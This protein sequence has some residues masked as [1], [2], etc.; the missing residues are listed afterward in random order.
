MKK[1]IV[2]FSV[3]IIII[4]IAICSFPKTGSVCLEEK[5]FEVEV[6]SNDK[7][8]ALGLMFRESLDQNKGMLF[9][10]K[11]EDNYSFWMKNME[12][13]LD[14]IWIN[15]EREIVFI[16][17]Y[18]QPCEGDFCDKILSDKKAKYVLELNA[19][20]TDDLLLKEGD[21]I[22]ISLKQ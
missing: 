3:V 21:R 10:F 22:T 9:V 19:G 6:V 4:L 1:I 14:I 16:E 18:A 15:K 7:K 12:F 20:I 5:C 8:R 11:E 2:L 13:P 17:K